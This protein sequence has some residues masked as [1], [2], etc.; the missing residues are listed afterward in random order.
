MNALCYSEKAPRRSLC[1]LIV[2]HRSVLFWTSS[3]FQ[4]GNWSTIAQRSSGKI[5]VTLTPSF[6]DVANDGGSYAKIVAMRDITSDVI[7][8]R[9]LL[10]FP[11]FLHVY[12]LYCGFSTMMFTSW[13]PLPNDVEGVTLYYYTGKTYRETYSLFVIVKMCFFFRSCFAFVSFN[14]QTVIYV[15]CIKQQ[16]LSD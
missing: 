5:N 13:M 4:R 9:M 6:F 16:V 3:C 14:L 7:L 15:E 10:S 8:Q 11:L 12:L 1:K 2:T